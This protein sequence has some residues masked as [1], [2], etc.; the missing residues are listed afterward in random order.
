MSIGLFPDVGG[1]WLLNRMPGRIGM[2]LALTGAQ[3]NTA[4]AFFAGLAD[5]RLDH[6]DWPKL[7]ESL[8]DQ[9]WAGRRR[10][11]RTAMRS[12]RSINDG[13]LRRALTALEPRTPLDPGHLR[14]QHSFLINN[15]CSGNRL[16]DIYEE[17]AALKDHD[18]PWLARAASTM[19]AAR[20]ARSACRSRCSS[21]C[22]CARD[23]V[24]R[25]S[26]SP[27]WHVP[28]MAISPRASARC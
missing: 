1:S 14:Q 16:D 13:L 27:R 4:D 28:R 19:L 12:P 3:L 24:F 22:G 9:P 21:A 25:A 26:T 15:L 6:A 18:D 10:P 5:F 8:Q 20:P 11:R 17:L 7:L 23:D 2:F